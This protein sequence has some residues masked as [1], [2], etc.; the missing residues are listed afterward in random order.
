MKLT[1]TDFTKNLVRIN[2]LQF[3]KWIF[4]P[5]MLFMSGSKWWGG[6]GNRTEWHNGLDLLRYEATDGTYKNVR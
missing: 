3:N 6:K 2:G 4:E 5:G 1:K